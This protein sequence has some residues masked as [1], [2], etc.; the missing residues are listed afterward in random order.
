MSHGDRDLTLLMVI[1]VVSFSLVWL[2]FVFCLLAF[3]VW[4]GLKWDLMR[5]RLASD[6]VLLTSIPSSRSQVS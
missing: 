5:P 3:A 2:D 4:F 6:S 1:F